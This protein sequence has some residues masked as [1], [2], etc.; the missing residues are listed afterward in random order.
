M[1]AKDA[2]LSPVE[3]ARLSR[4]DKKILRGM[5]TM[6]LY[7]D[8]LSPGAIKSRQRAKQAALDAIKPSMPKTR[9]RRKYG[10]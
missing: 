8:Q 7:R 5:R 2:G 6:E 1:T 9:P 3:W 4:F 10:R